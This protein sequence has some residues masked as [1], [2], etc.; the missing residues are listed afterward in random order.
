MSQ[1]ALGR[2]AALTAFGSALVA[3]HAAAQPGR[4]GRAIVGFPP[5][6]AV[7][8]VTRMY[9]ERMRAALGSQVIVDN[10]PGAGGRLALDMLKPIAVDGNAFA[11]TPASM[12]TIYPHLYA[13][14][15]R[16][17]PLADFMPV[18][19]VCVFPFGFAVGARHPARNVQEF[20]T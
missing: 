19:P 5:G 4:A 9:I 1:P 7:D 16:Y 20:I 15:L 8:T 2:R 12:L 17:D 6:G 14:T 13:R 11:V 3:G 10:R 18:S